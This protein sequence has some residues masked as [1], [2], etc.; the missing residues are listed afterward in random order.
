MLVSQLSYLLGLFIRVALLNLLQMVRSCPY[1]FAFLFVSQYILFIGLSIRSTVE[2]DAKSSDWL[3]QHADLIQ[4]M[5]LQNYLFFGNASSCLPY[6]ESMFEEFP[7]DDHYHDLPP[8]PAVVVIDINLVTGMDT[9]AIDVFHDIAVLCKLNSC[10]VFVSGASQNVRR[11]LISRGFE[12]SKTFFT[13][14]E[15][16]LGA[17]E[18]FILKEICCYEQREKTRV[19]RRMRLLSEDLVSLGNGDNGFL[20]ALQQID[21]QVR[22]VI[23][24]SI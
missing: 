3:D 4:V 10:R 22:C 18:D 15:P 17:A 7:D 8:K 9:S 24:L 1:L 11:E 6:I 5:V 13:A 12:S 19:D 16:A 23:C 21:E 20:H 14:L 2:R